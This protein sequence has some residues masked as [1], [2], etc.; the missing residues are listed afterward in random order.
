MEAILAMLPGRSGLFLRS[1][2]YNR[3][4]K[5]MGNR[6]YLATG[7]QIRNPQN[8][9]LGNDI[10]IGINNQLLAGTG[11]GKEYIEI[12]DRSKTNSNVII[13][14][15]F[16]GRIMIGSDVLIGPNT[17]IRSSNHLFQDKSK[18]IYMQGHSSGRIIIGDD[19]WIAA[20]VTILPD[21]TIGKG[22]VIAA[23]AVVNRNISPYTVVGGVPAK[24]IGER[25]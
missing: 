18:T 5:T 10:G 13:N 8:I 17:V 7:C 21:V 11:P 16:G 1:L 3:R 19:V 6:T 24:K 15:D 20:N 22:A 14:A 9:V 12:G 25:N 4:F 23:G 2:Y